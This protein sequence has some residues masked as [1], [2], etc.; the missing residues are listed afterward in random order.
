VSVRAHCLDIQT[1][2]SLGDVSEIHAHRLE[3]Q[4]QMSTVLK[5]PLKANYVLLVGLVLD[6]WCTWGRHHDSIERGEVQAT[7]SPALGDLRESGCS[8][9][10]WDGSCRLLDNWIPNVRVTASIGTWPGRSPAED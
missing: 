3:D 7:R 10:W 1:F 6:E 2:K 4:A 8:C 5:R 9:G